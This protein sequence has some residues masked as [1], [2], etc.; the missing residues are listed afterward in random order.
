[1]TS[2]F[3]PS[4]GGFPAPPPEPGPPPTLTSQVPV[5]TVPAPYVFQG[6]AAGQPQSP[7]HRMKRSGL[8]IASIVL[9]IVALIVAA[10]CLGVPAVQGYGNEYGF[11]Y[12]GLVP[13]LLVIGLVMLIR[14]RPTS[15]VLAA[16]L[17]LLMLVRGLFWSHIYSLYSSA[18]DPIYLS[19]MVSLCVAGF[20][21][22]FAGARMFN[23]RPVSVSC[24][25]AVAEALGVYALWQIIGMIVHISYWGDSCFEIWFNL[26]SGC[27][28]IYNRSFIDNHV[29]LLFLIIATI[30]SALSVVAGLMKR[31][32]IFMVVTAV[33]AVFSVFMPIFYY[34]I[35]IFFHH[36]FVI[37]AIM[38]AVIVGAALFALALM[39]LRRSGAEWFAGRWEPR[40]RQPVSHQVA[41]VAVPVA[42][43]YAGQYA[44]G[45]PAPV[46]GA[47]VS[48]QVAALLPS[49]APTFWISFFFGLFGLI[50]MSMANSM[51]A[52]LGAV[53]NQYNH[54]FLK[55]WLIGMA[56]WIAC[57]VLVFVLIM[58]SGY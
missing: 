10:A 23:G 29:V 16:A 28:W 13:I 36:G 47:P 8:E 2:S 1:M 18:V 54:A 26:V 31:S 41:F 44:G 25:L 58:S 50:P 20:I 52:R 57:Y 35:F 15:M 5:P 32:R 14:R 55:G 19:L 27:D 33:G 51:A 37:E 39:P 48:P 43:Q 53:T 49:T 4:P 7:A 17:P 21:T 30:T 22:C 6:A 12:Y 45:Q 42:G 56:A 34:F 9:T 40:V 46:V 3:P 11:L 38:A 24:G